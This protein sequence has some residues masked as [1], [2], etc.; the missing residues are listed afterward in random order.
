M[1]N[2]PI[3]F[4]VLAVVIVLRLIVNKIESSK[5]KKAVRKSGYVLQSSIL[6][7]TELKFFD[8]LRV[9]IPSG[10]LLLIKPRIADF[11]STSPYTHSAFNRI[12]SKHVDFLLCDF[13]TL[14]P[15]LAIELDDSSHNSEK[16]KKRD[17]FVESVY[18]SVNLPICRFATSRKYDAEKI[19]ARISCIIKDF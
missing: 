3:L 11:V 17:S 16:A 5:R 12:K 10:L 19:S 2:F 4:T 15:V 14:A 6:T 9:S 18:E 8:I 13:E 7:K 1:D